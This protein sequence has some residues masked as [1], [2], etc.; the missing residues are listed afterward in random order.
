MRVLHKGAGRLYR[1]E[2]NT[3][4]QRYITIRDG[5]DIVVG[6]YVMLP[7][8]RFELHMVFTRDIRIS[9]KGSKGAYFDGLSIRWPE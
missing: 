5:K 1:L 6:E 7:R 4:K 3:D 9:G 8:V 2:N